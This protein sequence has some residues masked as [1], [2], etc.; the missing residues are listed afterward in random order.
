LL[1]PDNN[2]TAIQGSSSL[3]QIQNSLWATHNREIA[4]ENDSIRRQGRYTVVTHEY[5]RQ[6]YLPL[7]G[8]PLMWWKNKSDYEYLKDFIPLVRK[9]LAIPA[10][11][12]PAESLFSTAGDLISESRSRLV[13]EHVDMLLFLNR[14]S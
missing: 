13:S 12:C 6:S 11:S 4:T 5:Q 14:N 8:D 3:P 2:P 10:T 7:K 9:Y 1:Y